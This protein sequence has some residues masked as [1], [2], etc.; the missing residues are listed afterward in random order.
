MSTQITDPIYGQ[1]EIY[2]IERTIIDTPAFQ[3]LR[4]IKVL[5]NVHFVFPGATHTRFIHSLGTMHLA[6]VYFDS[7]FKKTRRMISSNASFSYLRTIVRLAGLL[8]DIG[9]GPYS[10]LFEECLKIPVE[11]KTELRPCV[12]SDLREE[13]QIP[14]GWIS[15]IKKKTY[16]NNKLSHE[17]YSLGIIK[18]IAE[19]IEDSQFTLEVARDICAIISDEIEPSKTFIEHARIVSGHYENATTHSLLKC[20]HFMISGELDVDKLDYLVRDAYYCGTR[21]GAVDV[22][23]LIQSLELATETDDDGKRN[24]Y[25]EMTSSAVP[26]FEQ[27]LVSRKQM[28]NRVYHHRV[29]I[30]FDN[31]AKEIVKELVCKAEIQFPNSYSLFIKMTDEWLDQKIA[32]VRLNHDHSAE[33]RLLAEMFITRT[34]PKRVL[35]DGQ[36]KQDEIVSH[37]RA[38]IERRMKEL[39]EL[40][41][42]EN[43][44]I[45]S[46]DMK[47]ITKLTRDIKTRESDPAVVKIKADTSKDRPRNINHA[48]ELL[49]SSLWRDVTT[50]IIVFQP[51]KRSSEIRRLSLKLRL[52]PAT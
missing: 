29:N 50:R 43:P 37:E 26:A 52:L 15:K 49:R 10:H 24:F 4:K 27:L 34:M 19:H 16:G 36:S 6:G 9:H 5:G 17:D 47:E 41:R 12:V 7:L 39:K 38:E 28:F 11:G 18:Y 31:M 45:V 1:I 48:S 20:L 35:I 2:D 3:K 44:V 32:S 51:Y 13:L 22:G 42:A 8:H 14:K 30:A 25:I 40:Y 46:T 33:I 21:I 23:F